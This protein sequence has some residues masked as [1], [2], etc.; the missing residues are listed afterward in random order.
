[1]R[2][3]GI[4]TRARSVKDLNYEKHQLYQE[5]K[6]VYDIVLL[7]DPIDVIYQFI[8]GE[9]KPRITLNGIDLSSL[10]ALI[11][12]STRSREI[13]IALL[14]RSLSL[15]GCKILDPISRFAIGR[16]SKLLTTVKRF[17]KG[18]GSN[19]FVAFNYQSALDLVNQ[20]AKEQHFPLITKSM[21]GRQGKG[22]EVIR[23]TTHGIRYISLFFDYYGNGSPLLLQTFVE[24][25]S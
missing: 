11:I 25:V 22:I 17:E 9:I 5:A 24:F 10:N 3:I 18:I 21:F 15:C 23:D 14:T 16:S 13:S 20:L 6:K 19:T 4:C 8:R 7:I 12:R 1:M 2:S